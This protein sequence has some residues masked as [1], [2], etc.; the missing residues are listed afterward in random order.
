MIDNIK[1]YCIFNKERIRHYLQWGIPIAIIIMVIVLALSWWHDLRIFIVPSLLII[2]ISI[3]VFFGVIYGIE[4]L[5]WV[6]KRNH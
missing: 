4:A 5:Y 6:Y 2:I 1:I 3:G